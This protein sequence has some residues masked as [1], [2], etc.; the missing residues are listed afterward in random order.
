MVYDGMQFTCVDGETSTV[1]TGRDGLWNIVKESGIKTWGV[2][3]EEVERLVKLRVLLAAAAEVCKAQQ[4]QDRA[5]RSSELA[6]LQELNR[7][8][9]EE[10]GA[11]RTAHRHKVVRPWAVTIA[12]VHKVQDYSTPYTFFYQVGN[13]VDAQRA[14]DI[15]ESFLVEQ[16]PC[17]VEVS[18]WDGHVELRYNGPHF[19]VPCE[20]PMVENNTGGGKALGTPVVISDLDSSQC[21]TNWLETG[22]ELLLAGLPMRRYKRDHGVADTQLYGSAAPLLAAMQEE[23]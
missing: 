16:E 1:Q 2:T 7:K 21:K 14:R 17:I 4:E 12:A 8:K 22:E 9:R 5:E 13:A 18:G 3:S 15:H 11:L 6:A 20:M 19:N 10:Q 23:Q